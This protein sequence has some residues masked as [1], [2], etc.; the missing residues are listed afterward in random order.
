MSVGEKSFE[1]LVEHRRK[2][3]VRPNIIEQR[4]R[5]AKHARGIQQLTRRQ[6]R[7]LLCAGAQISDV[8]DRAE[9]GHSLGIRKT[10]RVGRSLLSLCDLIKM[11]RRCKC[12]REPMCEVA[13]QKFYLSSLIII[14]SQ[15]H[16]IFAKVAIFYKFS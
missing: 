5:G 7:A 16:F 3:A 11:L 1:D 6:D 8:D 4:T 13:L 12:K 10:A 2:E 9:R 15:I 14:H